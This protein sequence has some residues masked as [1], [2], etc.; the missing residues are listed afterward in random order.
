MKAVV[1]IV[2][3]VS[4]D[5]LITF[6]VISYKIMVAVW[7]I[8]LLSLSNKIQLQ[9]ELTDIWH[10]G[11]FGEFPSNFLYQLRLAMVY[12]SQYRFWKFK[13]RCQ[14]YSQSSS[15]IRERSETN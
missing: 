3:I 12:E 6:L 2:L 1:N 8:R 4:N 11:T 7:D 13:S 15:N 14:T 5:V 10:N 9:I